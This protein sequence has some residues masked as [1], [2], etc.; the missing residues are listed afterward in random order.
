MVTQTQFMTSGDTLVARTPFIGFFYLSARGRG[1]DNCDCQH[2]PS[3]CHRERARVALKV[4]LRQ[5]SG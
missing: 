4:I 1:G 2:P 3:S 5:P